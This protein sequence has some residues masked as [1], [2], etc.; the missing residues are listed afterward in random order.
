MIDS[1]SL[2]RKGATPEGSRTSVTGSLHVSPP[3]GDLLTRIAVAGSWKRF[4]ERL[5]W[6]ATPLGANVT[7]GSE[8]RS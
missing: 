5:I 3:F 7:Q 4:T 6:Y 8:A 1:L 2:N